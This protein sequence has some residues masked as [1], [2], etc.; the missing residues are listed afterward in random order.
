MPAV[1]A[2]AFAKRTRVLHERHAAA[3]DRVAR[4]APSARRRAP[5][6][7]LQTRSRAHRDRARRRPRRASRT[8]GASPRGRRARG[9]PPSGGP[10][11]AR[12][13]RRSPRGCRHAGAPPTRSASQFCP[14]CSSPSPVITTTI[15]AAAEEALRPGHAAAL[16]QAHAERA[17]VR[18][19]AGHADV[20]MAV[21]PAEAAEPQQP[22]RRDHAERVQR[23]VEA[24]DVVALRRE[25]DV[26]VR[27]VPAELGDVELAPEQVH[28]DVQRAEARAEMSRAGALDRDERV[29]AAH[30]GEQREVV[31]RALELLAGDQLQRRHDSGTVAES[32]RFPKSAATATSANMGVSGI[33]NSLCGSCESAWTKST[34]SPATSRTTS[35]GQPRGRRQA[36]PTAASTSQT[37]GALGR[38]ELSVPSFAASHR[39]PF[40]SGSCEFQSR[41][42][43]VSST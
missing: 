39:R 23:R 30:V 18:L 33:E 40:R 2:A 28:D 35:A 29:R 16:G 22:L 8:H 12:F 15:A 13:G 19:D 32:V 34:S 20:R 42:W 17:G 36:S 21:E 31:A 9:S 43:F 5:R 14:S 27:I 37:A 3:L 4:R 24:G 41:T 26:A 1:G 38:S 25:E 6:A 10:T 11:A 7:S